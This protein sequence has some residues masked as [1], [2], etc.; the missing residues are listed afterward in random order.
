MDYVEKDSLIQNNVGEH[1]AK[2]VVVC[3]GVGF[4]GL[5]IG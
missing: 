5:G 3:F 4:C 1:N 2:V